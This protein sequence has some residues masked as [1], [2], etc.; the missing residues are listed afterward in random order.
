MTRA[1]AKPVEV[2]AKGVFGTHVSS[3]IDAGL[4]PFPVHTRDKKPAVNGWQSATRAKAKAW[5]AKLGD[6]DGIGF[7]MGKPSGIVEVDVDAVGGAYLQRALEK[8]GPT[9]I[10]IETASGKHKLWYRSNGERRL[11][12]P[13][14]VDEPIDI[15]GAGFT[16]APPSERSDLGSSYKFLNGGLGD[17]RDLPT[18]NPGPIADTVPRPVEA[19]RNGERNNAAFHYAMR[20]ARHS[21]SLEALIDAVLTWSMGMPE[22]LPES[23]VERVASSAWGYEI[24]GVNFVGTKRPQVTSQDIIQDALAD[25]PDA[26]Y[27]LVMFQR[28]HSKRPN[29]VISPRAMSEARNP[30]WDWKR[31]ARAKDVLLVRGTILVERAPRRGRLL[32][33]YRIAD[34]PWEG[35]V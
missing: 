10:V 30:P 11:I 34:V 5:A 27:L 18:I 8:F 29:F 14:G 20:E 17:P 1:H 15:L 21:D 23:E 4:V 7:E 33:L 35:G 25:A 13:F 24:R 9:P 2:G 26:F 28:F 32:G 22:P 6:A 12:R 31:I 19:V 16:I 3:Y